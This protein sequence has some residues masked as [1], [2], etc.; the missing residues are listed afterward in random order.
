MA[1]GGTGET[2]G[3]A[4]ISDITSWLVSLA[5]G[6][7]ATSTTQRGA[8]EHDTDPDARGKL[9]GEDWKKATENITLCFPILFLK[10]PKFTSSGKCFQHLKNLSLGGGIQRL[11]ISRQKN[12]CGGVHLPSPMLHPCCDPWPRG[13]C[14][15]NERPSR[16][17]ATGESTIEA[18]RAFFVSSAK[19]TR[20]EP[21]TPH[22]TRFHDP[23]S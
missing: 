13:P 14:P 11:P 4:G 8:A 6:W 5:I 22:P 18:P 19:T 3:R 10:F 12:S 23:I 17:A 7:A 2:A 16:L 21:R 1:A 20:R 15:A 9:G